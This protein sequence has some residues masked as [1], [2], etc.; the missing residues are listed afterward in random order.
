VDCGLL[1]YKPPFWAEQETCAKGQRPFASAAVLMEPTSAASTGKE[2]TRIAGGAA[3]FDVEVALFAS[4]SEHMRIVQVQAPPGAAFRPQEPAEV[5][6]LLAPDFAAGARDWRKPFNADIG[7]TQFRLQ[8]FDY[9]LDRD[10]EPDSCVSFLRYMPDRALGGYFCSI[11]T[12][13]GVLAGALDKG[14]L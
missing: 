3:A 6:A 14:V 7:G 4:R 8:L 9:D 13:H 12:S 1:R 11:V 10:G 2:Q 5:A